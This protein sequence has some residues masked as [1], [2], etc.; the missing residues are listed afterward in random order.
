MVRTQLSVDAIMLKA[1]LSKLHN[2]FYFMI[3]LTKLSS[4]INPVIIEYK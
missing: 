1:C 3:A 2:L 4:G